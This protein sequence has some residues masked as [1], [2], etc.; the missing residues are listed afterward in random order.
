MKK[1]ILILSFF[2][3]NTCSGGGTDAASIL[4][5]LIPEGC[6][7]DTV[8]QADYGEGW[9]EISR[10]SGISDED[11]NS[12]GENGNAMIVLCNDYELI[13]WFTSD[14]NGNQIQR[15]IL[16]DCKAL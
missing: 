16:I 3:L 5:S 13:Q 12:M 8:E 4:S 14:D 9:V 6:E 1:L 7:C 10:S 15:R 2:L 11:L